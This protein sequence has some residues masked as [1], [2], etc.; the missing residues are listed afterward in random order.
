MATYI[1]TKDVKIFID[2]GVSISPNRYSLPPCKIELERYHSM[3]EVVR[4]WASAADI[5]IVTHYHYDHHNPDEPEVYQDKDVFLKHPREFINESQKE[6]AE[7]FLTRIESYARSINIA[8]DTT[9]SFGRTRLA[10]SRPVFHG[11]SA[12]LGYVIQVFIEEDK[13]FIFTSDVQGP[14]NKE[15]VNFIIEKQPHSMIIDGPL[16]YLLGSHYRQ[17]DIDASLE[18]LKR[19]IAETPIE[20][21]VIDHH[22]LRDLDWQDYLKALDNIKNGV[23]ICSAARFLGKK[24]DLLEA[25]RKEIYDAQQH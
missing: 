5:I 6:R 15:A 25:R 21:L 11:V 7:Y 23:F 4:Y 22:L 2:P 18:N 24:E 13:R 19:I 9:L 17:E 14:V 3:W 10:F 1:E 8:D 16:T 12:R 20:N